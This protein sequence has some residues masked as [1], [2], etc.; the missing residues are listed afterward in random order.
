MTRG[1]IPVALLSAGLLA[2]GLQPAPAAGSSDSPRPDVAKLDSGLQILAEA[3]ANG[4]SCKIK[5]LKTSPGKHKLTVIAT[6][7]AGLV[8]TKKFKY[9]IL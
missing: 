4:L 7:N 1:L 2:F 3:A 8:T 5:G 9:K 6:D